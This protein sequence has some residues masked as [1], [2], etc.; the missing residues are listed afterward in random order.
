MFLNGESYSS[1]NPYGNKTD[2]EKNIEENESYS[3]KNPYGNKTLYRM[4]ITKSKSYS[5][6]NPYGNKTFE[7][8]KDLTSFVLF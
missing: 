6:K 5:S 8:N 4:V 2:E 7:L 1:K 3:S